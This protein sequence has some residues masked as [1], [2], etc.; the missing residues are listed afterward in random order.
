VGGG[1]GGESRS[2]LQAWLVYHELYTWSPGAADRAAVA[3]R[4]HLLL[5]GQLSMEAL[6]KFP[7]GVYW[8][9]YP[10]MHLWLHAVEGLRM[11]GNLTDF[12]C[13]GD[14][15]MIGAAAALAASSHPRVMGRA[16][17]MKYR[18]GRLVDATD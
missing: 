13:Y 11:H 14:E 3:A 12:W 4:R 6:Q 9:V 10:K 5:Y 1:G 18:L 2:D 15:S 17:M 8:R 16:V 7:S